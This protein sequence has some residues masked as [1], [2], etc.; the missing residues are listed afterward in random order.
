MLLAAAGGAVGL[1]L[2]VGS[3]RALRA[4]VPADLGVLRESGL[5]GKVLG[6]TAVVCVA[7]GIICGLLP[8]LRALRPNLAGA[9]KQGSKGTGGAG[10]RR[11]H[12]V[13]VISQVAV[14]LVPL[15]GAG[16]LLRRLEPLFE[17]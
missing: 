10:S 13:L 8:A 9:L 6:F 16:L 5:H 7:T 11:T 4:F 1:L 17:V 2:A 3:L 12:N 14:A 15:L